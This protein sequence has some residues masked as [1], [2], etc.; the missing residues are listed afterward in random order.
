M[1]VLMAVAFDLS[2]GMA[3]LWIRCQCCKSPYGYS[4]LSRTAQRLSHD[5]QL[6][7]NMTGQAR[8]CSTLL[9]SVQLF[10]VQLP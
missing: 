4:R 5:I 10:Q 8:Y 7:R 6:E 9:W 3:T 2:L 1:P